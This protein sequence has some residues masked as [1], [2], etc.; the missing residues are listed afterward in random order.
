VGGPILFGLFTAMGIFLIFGDPEHPWF[1][2]LVAALCLGIVIWYPV[3]IPRRRQISGVH[4]TTSA[5][6]VQGA[7]GGGF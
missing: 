3:W 5:V 7:S 4:H 6:K 1:G 2:V